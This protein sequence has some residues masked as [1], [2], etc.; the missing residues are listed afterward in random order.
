MLCRLAG[1]LVEVLHYPAT[2]YERL[3]R[4]QEAHS[5]CVSHPGRSVSCSMASKSG[6]RTAE[7]EV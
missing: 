3:W 4:K 5:E 2:H 1:Q 7:V 6:E